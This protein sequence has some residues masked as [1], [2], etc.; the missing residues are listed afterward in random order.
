MKLEFFQMIFENNNTKFHEN[1]SSGSRVIPY[2]R[3]HDEATSRFPH[4]CEST[5]KTA[6]FHHVTKR[7]MK[8]RKANNI[9][10]GKCK[11][12]TLLKNTVTDE[13]LTLK[14]ILQKLGGML[15]TS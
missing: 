12:K 3:S 15:W 13:T 10:T 5:Y 7:A 11:P 6:S 2:G 14:W 4:F 1:P 9:L 8:I